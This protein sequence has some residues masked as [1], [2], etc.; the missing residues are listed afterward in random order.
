MTLPPLITVV[1]GTINRI[2]LLQRMVQSARKEAR[3]LP[4]HFIIVDSDSSDGTSEWCK[5]K[6][7]ELPLASDDPAQFLD[8]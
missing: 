6:A 3:F 5:P 7:D 8:E 1:T 2:D 4:I